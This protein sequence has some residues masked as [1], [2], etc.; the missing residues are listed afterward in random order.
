MGPGTG[1]SG[2][3]FRMNCSSYGGAPL[4][5]GDYWDGA[6]RAEVDILAAYLA[7]A[8][9]LVANWVELAEVGYQGAIDLALQSAVEAGFSIASLP[10][11]LRI[12]RIQARTTLL[13][14]TA[15]FR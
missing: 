14:T 13:P 12:R 4:V 10:G 15:H 6:F 2:S 8:A 1:T 7:V 11:R 5:F 9:E 3:P